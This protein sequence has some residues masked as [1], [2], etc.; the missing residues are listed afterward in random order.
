MVRIEKI[1]HYGPLASQSPATRPPYLTFLFLTVPHPTPVQALACPS[2]L[3]S[4]QSQV[5]PHD[6]VVTD[7]P[8]GVRP[9]TLEETLLWLT[10][11]GLQSP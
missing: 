9:L 5:K 8:A 6:L 7:K 1:S 3:A 10:R 4:E 2:D 11:A